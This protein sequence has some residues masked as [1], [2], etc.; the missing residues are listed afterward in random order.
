MTA[1]ASM[2]STIG[3][4]TSTGKPA[5][6]D[7]PDERGPAFLTTEGGIAMPPVSPWADDL[8]LY[9]LVER[10]AGKSRRTIEMR[11][12]SVRVMSKGLADLGVSEPSKVTR[13]IMARYLSDQA[14]RRTG[15]GP[16]THFCDCKSFWDWYAGEYEARSPMTGLPRPPVPVKLTPVLTNAELSAVL[17]AC[18]RRDFLSL[19]DRALILLLMAT[20][21]RRAEVAAL[22]L[23]DVDL[24]RCEAVVR[25][26][27]G[28]K[29]R[30]VVF[31]DETRLALSRYLRERHRRYPSLRHGSCALFLSR[32]GKP[33]TPSGLGQALTEIGA[34][35]GVA[36]L[37]AH[38]FRHRW[39][40]AA[41][42]QGMGESN[43]I[44]LAGWTSGD[45]LR[46]YGAA[47]REERARAAGHAMPLDRIGGSR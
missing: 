35:S 38:L 23:D 47:L 11:L 26:G 41:L 39:A 19:R 30:I 22:I 45:Q 43:I 36:G 17:S 12:S 1:R 13:A 24:A 37:R 8:V 28:G 10:S 9:E 6:S 32:D 18:A 3:L 31:G 42:D 4:P 14:Q 21:A 46:R 40:H 27:K 34:R 25:N 7:K 16:A 33:L 2:T 15:A 20:G 5:R 44:T 29:T